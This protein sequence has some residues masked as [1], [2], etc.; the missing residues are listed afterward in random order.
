MTQYCQVSLT[1][2]ACLGTPADLPPLLIGNVSAELLA[3]LFW[4]DPSHGLHGTGYWPVVDTTMFDP[5]THRV[6]ADLDGPPEPDPEA[7]VVRVRYIVEPLP[8]ELLAARRATALAMPLSPLTFARR[9]TREERLAVRGSDDPVVVD[10]LWLL[11]RATEVRLDD[12][13]TRAGVQYLEQIG[14][15]AAGRAAEILEPDQP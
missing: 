10:F 1:S 3:D 9:L 11:D 2:G 6:T 5:A 4:T 12:A 15:L 8:A 13:E 7:R 14:L